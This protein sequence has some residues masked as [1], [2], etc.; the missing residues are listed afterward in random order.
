LVS[1]GS[2]IAITG[3]TGFIGSSL[4]QRLLDQGYKVRALVRNPSKA[5]HLAAL[6]VTLV[7]GDLGNTAALSA[8]VAGA[9]GVIHGAGAVRGNCQADFDKVN[10]A[11]T[12]ALVAVLKALPNSPRLVHLSSIV[13]REPQLSWYSHS[14]HEGENIVA[15]QEELDWVIVRPPA[16]YGPGDKEMLPL[17]EMMQRGIALIPGSPDARTS[18][19]HVADLVEAILACLQSEQ[20]SQQAFF[21]GDGTPNGY[22][23]REIGAI[24]EQL[25]STRVRLW[26]IPRWLLDFVAAVISGISSFSGAAAMLT[27]PKLRELR[28]NDWVAENNEITSAT[29]WEP[30]IRLA[31]G[32]ELL[33]KAAL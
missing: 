3:A 10:V 17:F 18:L 32:L 9:D 19:I 7:E 26:Q 11:G 31:Q 21:L 12:A 24:G 25:W 20:A 13:A 30:Q 23:W 6:G 2:L 16:V 28:H 15:A 8:L 33:K 27:P 14:K 5:T 29:G 22:S 4:C 1:T